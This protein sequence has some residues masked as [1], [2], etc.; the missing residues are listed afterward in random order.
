MK[1][2]RVKELIELL[3]QYDGDL[4]VVSEGCDCDGDVGDVCLDKSFYDEDKRYVKGGFDVV[5][6]QRNER[7]EVEL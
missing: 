3:Q 1:W 7:V 5:Y 4:F 6:L 2:L